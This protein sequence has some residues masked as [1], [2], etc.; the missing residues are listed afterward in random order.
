[1]VKILINA[2]INPAEIFS[3]PRGGGVAE[4]VS[5]GGGDAKNMD[6]YS[7]MN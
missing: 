2:V 5:R 1:M 3:N 4:G 7:H 6:S